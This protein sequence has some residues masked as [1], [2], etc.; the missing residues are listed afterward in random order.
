[1]R[2]SRSHSHPTLEEIENKSMCLRISN[3]VFSV[4]P[5][6]LY[7]T[8]YIHRYKPRDFYEKNPELMKA[9]DQIAE[10]FFCPAEPHLFQ[11]L[12][13]HLLHHDTFVSTPL[14]V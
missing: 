3:S 8:M 13:D 11:G 12:V 1:M 5:I 10:G 4:T 9:V 2:C 14:I 7:L 6:S